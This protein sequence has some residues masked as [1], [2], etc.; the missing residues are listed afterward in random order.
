MIPEIQIY[1]YRNWK[2]QK[3]CE[4]GDDAI[5]IWKVPWKEYPYEKLAFSI[6]SVEERARVEKF[7]QMPDRHRC[8][9]GHIALRRLLGAYG[10]VPPCKIQMSRGKYGKLSCDTD[11]S[12]DRMEFNLSHS[13]DWI[14]IALS[15]TFCLGVDVEEMDERK[16]KGKMA[17]RFFHPAEVSAYHLAPEQ[18]RQ[19]LFY[20]YWTAKEAL[21]K[22]RGDGLTHPTDS[23]AVAI[24]FNSPL[25]QEFDI[26]EDRERILCGWHVQ[27][28][29]LESR[30][31]ASIAY[32]SG[33]SPGEWR[34]RQP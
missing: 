17:E 1:D 23:F 25:E 32:R 24:D 19:V 5:H 29:L 11:Q 13:G 3:V 27:N 12:M 33:D 28:F 26:E 22:G 20:R 6:L 9:L 30:Y 16:D 21:L 31:M 7:A 14:V 8:A 34:H 18:E 2:D 4:L 10:G 15:R